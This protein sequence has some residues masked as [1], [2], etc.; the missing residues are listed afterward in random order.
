MPSPASA[1]FSGTVQRFD[2]ARQSPVDSQAI[3]RLVQASSKAG[4]RLIL[5][6]LVGSCNLKC[7]SC[8]VG[9]MAGTNP[10]GLITDETFEAV[11]AKLAREFPKA[12][13]HFYNWTE[14]LIHPRINDYCKAAADAGFHLHLSSNLNHLKN[15]EGLMASGMK[16]FRISLSGSTQ[17]VYEMGHRGGKIEKVKQ[18]MRRLSAAKKATGSRTRIHVYFHKYRH[19]LHEVGL[20]DS[21]AREL[22]FDFIADWAFLMPVE[23]LIQY[24]EDDLD[25][26]QR[27]FANDAIVPAVN[28]ALALMQPHRAQPCEL[29]DQLVLDFRGHVSLCCAVYDGQRNFIGNYL[30]WSWERLQA[31]KYQHQSC[32]KCMHYGA[33]VLYTHFANPDLREAV[34]QLATQDLERLTARSRRTSIRLPV[35]TQGLAE[36]A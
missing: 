36:S 5:W 15:P 30:D 23:K 14:P 17:A 1:H 7:P 27:S 33:H 4:P 24:A 32:V 6:D 34:E 8:P 2:P 25:D 10:K 20:M 21:L 13:L 35:L 16:T 9:S 11:L 19:N 18:N 22:D 31:I 3:A 26:D 12:Q 29:I 28:D